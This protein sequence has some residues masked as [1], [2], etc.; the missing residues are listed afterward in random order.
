MQDGVSVDMK[1]KPKRFWSYIKTRRQEASCVAP[2]IYKDGF[3]QS[4]TPTKDE[5]LNEQFQSVYT[6]E[7]IGNI[8]YKRGPSPFTPMHE[9]SINSNGVKLLLKDY[10]APVPDGI[11]TFILRA[12]S[13]EL[14]P[15]L[16]RVY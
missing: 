4:N 15:I 14:A 10:K 6:Q 3:L 2:L 5:I 7:D 16:S 13:E 12:V 11:P 9:I 8:P 1:G